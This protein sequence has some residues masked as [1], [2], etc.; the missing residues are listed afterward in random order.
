VTFA[1][2]EEEHPLREPVSD[3]DWSRGPADASVALV[4]YLDFECPHCQAAYPE[5]ERMLRAEAGKVRFVARHFPVESSHPRALA[6]ALAAEAAGRQGKF[7]EMHAQLFEHPGRLDEA[8][9]RRY[10]KALGLH[11]ARFDADRADESLV[12]KIQHQKRQGI[13]SGVNGTP[14]LYING[15]RYDGPHDARS[16]S[17]VVEALAG[18]SS[19]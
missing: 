13:R 4:E 6:A 17:R 11:L 9:L 10:A 16:L 8:D 5:I 7:W 12:R 19:A 15:L 14:T 3:E 1:D 18:E 2:D